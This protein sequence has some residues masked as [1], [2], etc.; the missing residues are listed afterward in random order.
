MGT[1][2]ARRVGIPH[3]KGPRWAAKQGGMG[4]GVEDGGERTRGLALCVVATFV[5]GDVIMQGAVV[6]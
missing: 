6:M 5:T 2:A 3:F 1:F 4:L